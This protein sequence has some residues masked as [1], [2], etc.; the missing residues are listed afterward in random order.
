M[1]RADRLFQIIQLLR[2]RK[3]LT[4]R[5]LAEELE[6]SERTVYRDV[7]DLVSTGTQIDGE[8]G[9]GYSLRAGYD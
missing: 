4:A 5:Q 2:R 7:R 3:V 8:A 6:V 1:R 9:V